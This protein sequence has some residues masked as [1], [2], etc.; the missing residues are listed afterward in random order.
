MNAMIDIRGNTLDY[1]EWSDLGNEGWSHEEV[2]PY[3]IRA[4]NQEI[5]DDQFHGSGGPLNV[6]DRSYTN[7]LSDI[8]VKA[9]MEL[10]Y[11]KNNDFNGEQQ[12][13]FGYYQVTQKNGVRCSAATAYLHP[14]AKRTNLIIEIHAKVER[15]VLGK[16]IA[17]GVVYHQ[18]GES[19][20]CRS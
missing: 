8:F 18:S 14:V 20:E 3:F 6:T 15:I 13:G 12:K 2:L 9:G 17:T 16:G 4:E 7:H 11:T 1:D 19:R 10:G 5:I